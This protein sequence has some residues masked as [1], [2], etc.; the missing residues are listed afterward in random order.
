MSKVSQTKKLL[1]DACRFSNTRWAVEIVF[2]E[3][4]WIV[5][6]NSRITKNGLEVLL[7]IIN[8]KVDCHAICNKKNS[9]LHLT[10]EL[11]GCSNLYFFPLTEKQIFI[12]G[13]DL[14]LTE[15]DK[16]FWKLFARMLP[17]EKISVTNN[18][19]DLLQN[20]V[21]ELQLTQQELQAR[22]TA[23][24]EAESRLIQTAKL[25]AVGEMAAGVAHELNNPLTSVVGFAELILEDLPDDSK[26]KDDLELILKEAKRARSVVRR[27]LDFSRQNETVRSKSDINEIIIDVLA[28]VKHQM[29]INNIQFEA[30]LGDHLQWVLVDRN[31]I[32]QVIINL[33]TNAIYA[34]PAGGS[35]WIET[36]EQM[37][38]G[39][40][41]I[42]VSIRD[43]GIGIPAEN[44]ERIFEPFFT[45]RGDKGGT[46]L[47][48]SVTY[49]IVTD[50]GGMIE[51]ES[52]KSVGSTF[53]VWLPLGKIQ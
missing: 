32:K 9:G 33:I 1:I 7:E 35:L 20:K 11:D 8:N 28:L 19:V 21:L 4:S 13:N 49:G 40:M 37:R 50:H 2:M 23:Q 15:N 18:E 26:F 41:W 38:Y 39:Q 29:E 27:L 48:L 22:I 45:T 6:E 47:G 42:M 52:Q 16:K 51:V 43:N 24:L 12:T 30:K 17:V 25:A 46:G 10:E 44:M 34:M 31:Q 5:H 3:S 36:C 53:V 14:P